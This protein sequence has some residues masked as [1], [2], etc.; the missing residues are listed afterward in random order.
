MLFEE[1]DAKDAVKSSNLQNLIKSVKE[2]KELEKKA[3]LAEACL[4]VYE[5][6]TALQE[7]KAESYRANKK[8]LDEELS[9]LKA[10]TAVVENF[11]VTCDPFPLLEA[12]GVDKRAFCLKNGIK[13]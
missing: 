8:K 7:T 1:V 11:E 12:M 13:E 10:L 5:S 2:A 6:A 3:K 4:S 9:A